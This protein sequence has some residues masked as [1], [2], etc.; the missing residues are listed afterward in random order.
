MEEEE[1]DE[2]RKVGIRSVLFILDFE[3]EMKIKIIVVEVCF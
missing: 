1:K 2:R 3:Y